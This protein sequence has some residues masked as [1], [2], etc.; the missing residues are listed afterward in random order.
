MSPTLPRALAVLAL[1]AVLAPA[2]ARAQTPETGAERVCPTVPDTSRL[3]PTAQ[4][5]RERAEMRQA[6]VTVGRRHGVAEPQGLVFIT[7]DSTRKGRALFLE[8]NLSEA[9]AREAANELET[10]LGALE[11]GRSFQGLVRIG[12]REAV[13]AA[14]KRHCPPVLLNAGEVLEELGRVSE[15]RPPGPRPDSAQL[16][17]PVLRL[18]VNRDGGVSHVQVE[19]AHNDPY[20][21]RFIPEVAKMLKFTPATLDGVPF[22]VRIRYTLF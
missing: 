22:D 10:Y 14:G 13:M 11:G 19:R 2:S 8:T 18:V 1:L 6:L 9:A 5:S 20:L 7:V 21:D 3:I 16:R 4:Q 17:R 12:G 15:L